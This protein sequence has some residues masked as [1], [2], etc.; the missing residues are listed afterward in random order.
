MREIL[1][2]AG[3]RFAPTDRFA[4]PLAIDQTAMDLRSTGQAVPVP[5]QVSPFPGADGGVQYISKSQR[6]S[7]WEGMGELSSGQ[8]DS[9]A[10]ILLVVHGVD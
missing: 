6:D 9:M 4:M 2:S 5:G 1:R 3:N 8:L 10:T 7:G